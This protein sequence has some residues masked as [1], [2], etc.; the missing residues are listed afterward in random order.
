M[1][2]IKFISRVV[3]GF[4]VSL[5]A[6]D[7]GAAQAAASEPKE[8]TMMV[9]INGHNSLDTFG[10]LNINQME[11]IGSNSDLNIVV[12]WASMR[13][14]T[15]KRLLVKK[16]SDS[17][18]VTSPVVQEMP[19]VD[20][21]D[22]RSL[23]DFIRWTVDRYP[24]KKYF[25]VV[26]NHGTGWRLQQRRIASLSGGGIQP[27]DISNDD[28]TGSV[29]TTEQLGSV[30]REAA[31][32]IGRPIDLYGSDA[33][34]MSM[35]E[36]ATEMMGSVKAF[37][38]SEELEPGAG[39]PYDK[40]LRR[41]AENPKAEPLE[42]GRYLTEEYVE[43][44]RGTWRTTFSTL[45]MENLPA[46]ID[47]L[48]VFKDRMIEVRG[49]SDYQKAAREAV[50]FDFND[51]VDIGSVVSLI[52]ATPSGAAL[53][54]EIDRVLNA[55]SQVVTSNGTNCGSTGI[56]M[57]WPVEAFQWKNFSQRYRGLVFD[58]LS[59]WTQFLG[60]LF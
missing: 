20:M 26:W 2:Q 60:L 17:S 52:A 23:T 7:Q 6:L 35:I 46:L 38:G 33:C 58:Q 11:T 1:T 5:S 55:Y 54:P 32:Y 41:W 47:S 48:R 30:I 45:N 28:R 44:Y 31:A 13:F 3:V 24:A 16:D 25:V 8:W 14:N 27:T 34:L 53:K 39:W 57:W 43:N 36:V 12:Q 10:A 29:I 19:V 4:L 37:V 42:V 9:F 51:Y 56:A 50:R 21:G 59:G 15:T 40:F 22:H 18:T 49:M